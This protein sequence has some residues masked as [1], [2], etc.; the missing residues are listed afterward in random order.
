MRL[1]IASNWIFWCLTP[2]LIWGEHVTYI[3]VLYLILSLILICFT[4]STACLN[5]SEGRMYFF[6]H[7]YFR[8][9]TVSIRQK[10]DL[11]KKIFIWYYDSFL[12]MCLIII[13]LVN[14]EHCLGLYTNVP[15]ATLVIEGGGCRTT[16]H[17]TTKR[18]MV[19][20]YL[21]LVRGKFELEVKVHSSIVDFFRSHNQWD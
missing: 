1:Q 11:C 16:W 18:T 6:H 8:T 19:S 9:K 10:W 17:L 12:K 2:I 21:Y 7:L 5:I 15:T 3:N 4:A 13:C 20:D 14:Q